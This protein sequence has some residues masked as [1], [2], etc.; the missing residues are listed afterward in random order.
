MLT[1]TITNVSAAHSIGA[2]TDYPMPDPFNQY[3]IA[4]SGTQ[5]IVCRVQDM[6]MP[7]GGTAFTGFTVADELQKLVQSNVITVSFANLA[8]TLAKDVGGEAVS[9]E[10]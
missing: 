8:A 10:T 2:G 7:A 3:T 1:L 4:A 9:N 6:S 5:A